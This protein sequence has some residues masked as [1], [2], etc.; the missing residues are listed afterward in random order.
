MVVRQAGDAHLLVCG[1][2]DIYTCK[3]WLFSLVSCM[4]LQETPE[5]LKQGR[6]WT[7]GNGAFE[8]LSTPQVWC[9]C[10]LIVAC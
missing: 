5:C 10:I 1:K 7:K 6:L 2:D 4:G 8:T 3:L 9:A